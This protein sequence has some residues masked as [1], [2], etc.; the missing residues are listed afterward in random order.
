MSRWD[1]TSSQTQFAQATTPHSVRASPLPVQIDLLIRYV[2]YLTLSVRTYATIINHIGSL[3]HVNQLLGFGKVWD[4]HYRFQLVLRGVKRY[5]GVS[6]NCRH[7]ITPELLLQ[8]Y[9]QFTLAIPL[10]TAMWALFLV[11]FFTSLRKS[12]LVPVVA[13]RISTKVPLRA[14]LEFSSQGA[15][16]HIKASKTIQYQQRS[17]SIPLPCIPGYPL[18]QVLRNLSGGTSRFSQQTDEYLFNSFFSQVTRS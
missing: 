12:N 4:T 5:L 14:D 8:V 7:P 6:P 10:H 17:W 3:K 1:N 16:L 11:A 18:C 15:S 2:A 13:D 9:S